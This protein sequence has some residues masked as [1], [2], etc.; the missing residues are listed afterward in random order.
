MA[1]LTQQLRPLPLGSCKRKQFAVLDDD[2]M[3][4][5]A[6]VVTLSGHPNEQVH[7]KPLAEMIP[8]AAIGNFQV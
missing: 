6:H 8:F 7:Q 2:T 1:A 4:I 3:M 5:P